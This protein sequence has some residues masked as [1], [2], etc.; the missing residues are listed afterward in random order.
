MKKILAYYLSSYKD[1]E[2]EIQKKTQ[3]LLIGNFIIMFACIICL[4]TSFLGGFTINGIITASTFILAIIVVLISNTLLKNNRN[5][6]ASTFITHSEIVIFVG[7]FGSAL[8]SV[9]QMGVALSG[10]LMGLC[11]CTLVAFS[12]WQVIWYLIESLV[13]CFGIL[14]F[15]VAKTGWKFDETAIV[16][17]I[18]IVV[19]LSIGS[20]FMIALTGIID[21]RIRLS[22]KAADENQERFNKIEQVLE[23]SKDGINIGASLVESSEKAFMDIENINR[24]LI[25]IESGVSDLNNNIKSLHDAN[26]EIIDSTQD[27]NKS[28]EEYNVSIA[29]SSSAIEEMTASINNISQIT[30]NKRDMIDKLVVTAKNGEHEMKVASDSINKVSIKAEDILEIIDVIVNIASQTDLLAMNAAIE[31][32]HAGE[33]GKGFAVVADEVRNLAELTDSNIKIITKTLKET[34]QDIHASAQINETAAQTFNKMNK[35][36]MEV[37]SSIEE[38]I[39]GMQDMN[40]GTSEVL[41]GVSNIVSMSQ[42]IQ[43]ATK[44]VEAMISTSNSGISNISKMA[45]TISGNTSDILAKSGELITAYK[46]ISK[47]GHD[48]IN[49][50]EQIDAHI[51]EIKQL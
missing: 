49:Q 31:A 34:I 1:A 27:M 51:N 13:A 32:A 33:A 11:M 4:P 47:V 9:D 40:A 50:M 15:F 48:N 22:K 3:A 30:G 45:D 21:E 14:L 46:D 10:F 24:N 25:V 19:Y 2:L 8:K 38:V 39:N 43:A 41:Q 20:A 36:I 17:M 23:A 18:N 28:I 7:V 6:A 44:K 12:K 37:K 29:Q 16:M 26:S 35:E 42:A 5:K